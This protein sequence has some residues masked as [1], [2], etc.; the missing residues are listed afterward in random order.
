MVTIKAKTV[1]AKVAA[2]NVVPQMLAPRVMS[3]TVS[4]EPPKEGDKTEPQQKLTAEQRDKLVKQMQLDNLDEWDS[5]D[6]AEAKS[7][8]ADFG[9]IFALN[10]MDMG[11]T[12]V[13]KHEI[14]LTDY[15]PFKERY[16]RIPPHQ[17]E[18]VKKHLQEML[19]I[20][21]I[22]KSNSPWASAVVLI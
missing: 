11:K 7:I 21:A 9:H 19:E 22:H 5:E 6:I 20:G 1:I 2:A 4:S 15:T 3:A 17:F 18:E 12:S 14:K 8:I 16:R 10:D 13:V